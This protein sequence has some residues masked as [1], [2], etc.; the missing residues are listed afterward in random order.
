MLL[1]NE[2]CRVLLTLSEATATNDYIRI[3]DQIAIAIFWIAIN[4]SSRPI[5][6]ILAET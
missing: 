5:K 2:V 3:V 6:L 4:C 1:P